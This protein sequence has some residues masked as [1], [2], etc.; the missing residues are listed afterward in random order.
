M[1]HGRSGLKET[2]WYNFPF[3]L[4]TRVNCINGLWVKTRT[5]RD[6]VTIIDDNRSCR[7]L[8]IEKGVNYLPK[9]VVDQNVNCFTVKR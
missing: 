8:M 4:D 9:T 7:L 2:K 5:S 3:F 6:T 1:T